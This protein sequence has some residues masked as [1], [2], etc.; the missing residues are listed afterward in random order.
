MAKELLRGIN[1]MQ[2]TIDRYVAAHDEKPLLGT[3]NKIGWSDDT[4]R[5]LGMEK[6]KNITENPKIFEETKSQKEYQ[7]KMEN[8]TGVNKFLGQVAYGA[9][10]MIPSMAVSQL[11]LPRT[12]YH[13]DY[14][15]S[16]TLTT[17]R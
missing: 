5:F 2:D 4:Y 11:T 10:N 17:K 8:A 3:A 16:A 1:A 12:C 13:G 9:G 14:K 15:D 7:E 6:P